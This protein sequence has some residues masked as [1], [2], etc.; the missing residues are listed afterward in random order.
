MTLPN[1]VLYIILGLLR[2]ERDYSTLYQCALA[3]RFLAEH[4]LMLLYQ[5]ELHSIT[6]SLYALSKTN[7]LNV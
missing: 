7:I 2:D 5:Y 6:L 4:A 1:D 3:S